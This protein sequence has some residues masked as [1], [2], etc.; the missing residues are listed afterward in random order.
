MT[1]EELEKIY[2]KVWTTDELQKDFEVL[3]FSACLC[4]A[5]DKTTG[6]KCVLDFG[7]SPRFYW[8]V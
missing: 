3:G 6:E 7:G 5:K 8:K 2:G 4:V 1:R